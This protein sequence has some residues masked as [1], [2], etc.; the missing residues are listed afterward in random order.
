MIGL[1]AKDWNEGLWGACYGG[2][3]SCVEKMVELGATNT[4][5]IPTYFPEYGTK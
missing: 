5:I 1:G 2:H 4:N 3:L